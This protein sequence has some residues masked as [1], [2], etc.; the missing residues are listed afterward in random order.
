MVS[1]PDA[2]V[3]PAIMEEAKKRNVPVIASDVPIEG[4]YFLTHDEIQAGKLMG[5]Y[6]ADYFQKNMAGKKAKVAV[7][8]HQ[9]VASQVDQRIKGFQD[10]FSAKVPDA[11]FLPK[12]DAEGL[13]EK[14]ANLMAS[15]ITANPDVNIC[16]AINDDIALGAASA[17]EAAGKAKDIACFGQGG[18]GE[19]P[20]RALLDPNSP[21]KATSNF[22]PIG[23]GRTAVTDI[24]LPLLAG[25]TPPQT[26][27]GPLAVADNS[28]AQKFLDEILASKK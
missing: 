4:A 7:L 22:D 24:I 8:T 18:I 26:V 17:V 9:A 25:K 19:S 2:N 27:Q 21:F 3:G 13:R 12:Q 15:I 1:T 16:F 14:G 6:A 20:F 28:N 23:Y 11:V 10:A 5:D